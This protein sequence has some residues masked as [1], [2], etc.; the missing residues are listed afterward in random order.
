MALVSL[1][2]GTWTSL[3]PKSCLSQL[4]Q[5]IFAISEKAGV[6][7]SSYCESEHKQMCWVLGFCVICNPVSLTVPKCAAH[8]L[9]YEVWW[10]LRSWH[11][12]AS[13]MLYETVAFS[14][15]GNP[16]LLWNLVK[17]IRAFEVN[18]LFSSSWVLF[19]LFEFQ[20]SLLV[21]LFLATKNNYVLWTSSILLFFLD[22]LYSFSLSPLTCYPHV[23]ISL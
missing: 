6:V 2:Y 9:S 21:R 7:F 16:E 15:R 4:W 12:F 10:L 17:S 18:R 20:F 22:F 14:R 1:C 11:T 8:L 23:P 3:H 13:Y 19:W 5:T